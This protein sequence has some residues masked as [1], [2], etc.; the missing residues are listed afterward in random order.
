MDKFTN[1]LLLSLAALFPVL[2]ACVFFE[3]NKRTK[4]NKLNFWVKQ[5]IYGS[6]FGILA[7]LGTHFGIKFE[8]ATANVRDASVIISGLCFGWP[9]GIIAGFIGGFE[10]LII[11][12]IDPAMEFTQI[13]CS[14]STFIAGLAAAGLRKFIFDDERPR[15]M[16]GFFLGFVIE[17]FHLFM[18][19]VTRMDDYAKAYIVIQYCTAPMLIANSISVLLALFALR[20]LEFGKET[21]KKPDF[22]SLPHQTI[23]Y[24]AM[25]VF[26]AFVGSTLFMAFFE[27]SMNSRL[28]EGVVITLS[29]GVKISEEDLLTNIH[30]YINT[31][32]EIIVFGIVFVEMNLLSKKLVTDNLE[33]TNKSLKK[34]TAGNLDE[35]VQKVGITEFDELSTGINH[36]VT[37]LKGY[38]DAAN[39]RIDEELAFAKSIQTSVLPNVFPAFPDR[40]ELDIYA[41]MKTAKEV[42]GDFYDFYFSATYK[43]NFTIADVSGKGIPAALFMMRAKQAIKSL[44]ETNCP[45]DEVLTRANNSLCEGNDAGMFVTAWTGAIDLK[46]G[47][48]SFANGGHNP[49]LVKRGN[50]K[51]E[52]L[53]TKPNMVL[54]GME[55]MK[56]T[57]N[58]MKLEKGDIVY[59]YTDGVTEAIN[60][61]GEQFGEKR[62]QEALNSK[63]FKTSKDLCEHITKVHNKFTGKADQFDDITMVAFKYLG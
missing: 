34:I 19:F 23:I 7:I 4:F 48:L 10:R 16:S 61:K 21:F 41:S 53:R 14:V 58:E 29:N 51:F 62:L 13:A 27:K 6:T 35:V 18:V 49:P 31:F 9:A 15:I 2:I 24:L 32:L 52:Y 11:G 37:A 1:Y 28:A 22:K 39:K 56:Y 5:V 46:T 30:L 8:Y 45:I 33:Q 20:V 60:E 50:G 40:K 43:F 25:V 17:T 59:L 63:E 38:I 12:F 26:F 47:V 44:A 57:P 42:G 3:V 55:G 54:A 36:T